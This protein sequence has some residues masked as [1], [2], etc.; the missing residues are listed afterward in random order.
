MCGSMYI[1][2]ASDM[3]LRAQVDKEKK[4][5][6]EKNREVMSYSYTDSAV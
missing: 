5:G 1:G 3:R 4:S 6:R 2:L